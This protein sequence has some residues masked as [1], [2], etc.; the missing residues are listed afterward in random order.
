MKQVAA[1]EG[2][3]AGAEEAAIRYGQGDNSKD[4]GRGVAASYTVLQQ[5]A[6]R[7]TAKPPDEI[8]GGFRDKGREEG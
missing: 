8:R 7:A 3:L 4:D 5:D 1:G 2:A 6:A